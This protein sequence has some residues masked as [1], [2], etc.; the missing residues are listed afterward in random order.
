LAIKYSI[1]HVDLTLKQITVVEQAI[2]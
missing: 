2:E 1:M